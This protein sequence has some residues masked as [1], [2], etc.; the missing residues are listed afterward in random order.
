MPAGMMRLEIALADNRPVACALFHDYY[1]TCTYTFAGSLPEA[2]NTNAA[3]LLLWQAMLNAKARGLKWMDL[4]GTAP[5]G[6]ASSHPWAGFTAF[7]AKFGGHIEQY[8]GSWDLPL[9][10]RYH[11]YRAAHRLR[12]IIKRH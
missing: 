7:K 3:A 12:K 2:R 6:A 11:A 8:A 10:Q 9:N 5:E 4:Y 1:H